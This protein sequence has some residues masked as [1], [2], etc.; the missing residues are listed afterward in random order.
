V[1]RW[2]RVTNRCDREGLE[3]SNIVAVIR[4]AERLGL[5]GEY[6]A[7]ED[8]SKA[9]LLSTWL[10]S[11]SVYEG[12]RIAVRN[13]LLTIEIGKLKRCLAVTRRDDGG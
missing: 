3:V 8:D 9:A 6:G 1:L 10:K 7:T 11:N 5:D 13:V 4:Q 2:T 12:D